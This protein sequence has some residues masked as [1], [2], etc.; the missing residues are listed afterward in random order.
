MEGGLQVGSS[1]AQ[2]RPRQEEEAAQR[3]SLARAL[4][5]PPRSPVRPACRLACLKQLREL[6]LYD[7]RITSVA[8][9]LQSCS[10]L[11]SLNLSGNRVAGLAG[12]PPLAALRVL[13]IEYNGLTSLQ[14]LGRLSGLE[15]LHIGAN[16]LRDL[17][18]AWRRSF[19]RCRHP[20]AACRRLPP[21]PAPRRV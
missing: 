13:D 5:A 17:S 20:A 21:R 10:A 7:N 16:A 3:C 12:F 19:V 15:T 2:R 4:L 14:G 9:G 8:S 1:Q 6:K 11:Q 18:G